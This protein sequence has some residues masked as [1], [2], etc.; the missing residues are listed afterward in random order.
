MSKFV[1]MVHRHEVALVFCVF[2]ACATL[3]YIRMR[4]QG[5]GQPGKASR[6]GRGMHPSIKIGK[7]LSVRQASKQTFREGY[8]G[9]KGRQGCWGRR[10]HEGRRG[11]QDRQGRHGRA[12]STGWTGGA[13]RAST[14]GKAGK[15]GRASR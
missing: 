1:L 2:S 4:K 6:T 9:R 15:A 11:K 13:G 14:V 3:C 10:G 12:G 8:E 5:A 7:C